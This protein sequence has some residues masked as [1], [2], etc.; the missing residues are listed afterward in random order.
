MV[1]L[2]EQ[3]YCKRHGTQVSWKALK[4][5]HVCTSGVIMDAVCLSETERLDEQCNLREEFVMLFFMLLVAKGSNRAD[6]VCHHFAKNFLVSTSWID[7]A[8]RA[9]LGLA[10]Q[11]TP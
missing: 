11:T 9:S 7:V 2:L 5:H 3:R 6:T 4:T 1:I 8:S 10:F